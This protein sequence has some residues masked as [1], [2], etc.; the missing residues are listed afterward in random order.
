MC[1]VSNIGD[2]WRN[3]FLGRWPNVDPWTPRIPVGD[4][5][6]LK[7]E[8]EQLKLLLQAGRKFDNETGQ[9]KC[10]TEDKVALIKRLAEALGVDMGDVFE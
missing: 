8:V 1:T 4:L 5:E 6:A 10:E 3:G 9:A 7:K 2:S